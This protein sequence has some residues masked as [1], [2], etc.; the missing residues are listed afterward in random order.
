[1]ITSVTVFYS[2]VL[3]ICNTGARLAVISVMRRAGGMTKTVGHGAL[4]F[5]VPKMSAVQAKR[6]G[7]RNAGR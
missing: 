6:L 2:D 1:M 7:G 5:L 4:D 3:R